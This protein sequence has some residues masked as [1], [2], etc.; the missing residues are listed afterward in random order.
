MSKSLDLNGCH[1][2]IKG[3]FSKNYSKLFSSEAIREMKLKL[4]IHVHDISLYINCVFTVLLYNGKSGNWHLF[5]CLYRY[6]DK[7]FTEMFLE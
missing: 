2:N 1:G 7:R 6:F 3:K 4:S 5:L